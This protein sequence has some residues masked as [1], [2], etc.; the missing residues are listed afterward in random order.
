MSS[1][2]LILALAKVLIA[3]AWADGELLHEEVNSMKDL[4]WRLPQL[5]ARQWAS[6]QIYLE[7]PVEEAERARLVEELQD[8]LRSPQ[9]R[10]LALRTLDEMLHADGEVTA[11]EE[12]VAAEIRG[13]IEA[14]DL[15]LLSRLVKGMARRRTEATAEAPNREEYLDDFIH[16]K[17]Y[18][19]VRRRLALGEGEL[20]LDEPELRTLSLAGG[21]MAQVARV[22]PDAT[23]DQVNAMVEA[24]ERHWDLTKGEA[25]FVAG[26]AISETATLLDRYRLARRF[27]E[28][29][30]HEERAAFLEVLF[31]VAV[32]DGELSHDETEE[33]REISRWLK[34]S[35][36]EFIDAKLKALRLMPQ[37]D[38]P[39]NSE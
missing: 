15:G 13:A 5:S 11:E 38:M 16:N 6:L 37:G 8:A 3:A 17:V 35:H 30:S 18:Y 22:H 27:A 34:L 9:D 26:V 25:A 32:A 31:A 20:N 1:Q 29:C 10:A 36:R 24:L 21:M 28:A 12:R 4:L 14:V 23:D 7:A 39:T 2:S 33:I 19:G